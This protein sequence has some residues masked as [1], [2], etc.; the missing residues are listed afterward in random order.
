MHN[1]SV[2]EAAK[3][4]LIWEPVLNQEFTGF[5]AKILIFEFIFLKVF[6]IKILSDN[7]YALYSSLN[8]VV[9]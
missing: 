4:K 2:N 6:S 7:A 1:S 5:P 9:E 3:V 8:I